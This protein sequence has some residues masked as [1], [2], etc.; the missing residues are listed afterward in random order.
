MDIYAYIGYLVK[1][2]T[3]EDIAPLSEARKFFE[4]NDV[5]V[6]QKNDDEIIV[7]YDDVCLSEDRHGNP[8]V[9]DLLVYGAIRYKLSSF[10]EYKGELEEIV[11]MFF[12]KYNEVVDPRTFKHDFVF[13]IYCHAS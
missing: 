9:A 2:Q 5:K 12:Q 10:E 7:S 11:R 6:I 8:N 1:T 13:G 3:L 4:S